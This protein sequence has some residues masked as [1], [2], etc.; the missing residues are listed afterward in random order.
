ME[1]WQSDFLI[2]CL[3]VLGIMAVFIFIRVVK[4]PRLLDRIMGVN[5]MGTVTICMLAL[6][7][8]LQNESYLIDICII[9]AVISFLAVV[10]LSKIYMGVFFSGVDI[11]KHNTD[12]LKAKRKRKHK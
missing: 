11:H 5:M 12:N 3:I 8:I 7:S 1:K 10:V 6:V 4:G 9:Y 2:F